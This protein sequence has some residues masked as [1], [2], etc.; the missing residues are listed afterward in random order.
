MFLDM[1]AYSAHMSKNQ[2]HAMKRVN[3]LEEILHREV[4]RYGGRLVK[5]MGDGAMAEFPTAIAA[6]TCAEVILQVIRERNK[7]IEPAD[8]FEVRIG[9]HLGDVI[10]KDADLFG[11]TVNI[12]ARIQPFADKGGIAMSHHVLMSVRNQIK[13]KGAY[14]GFTKLKNIP[15]KVR[16]YLVP[17]LDTPYY[18]WI[19]MR[20]NPVNTRFRAVM[21]AL[22]TGIAIWAGHH[23][24]AGPLLAPQIALLYVT[25]VVQAEPDRT[26]AQVM[27]DQV[28]EEMDSRGSRIK[29]FRWKDHG[30]VANLISRE[31][32]TDRHNTEKVDVAIGSV[33]RKGRLA[34]YIIGRIEAVGFWSWMLKIRV[35]SGETQSVVATFKAKGDNPSDVANTIMNE[36]SAWARKQEKPGAKKTKHK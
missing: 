28:A 30:W 13:L 6:V 23:F 33:A 21:L 5:F 2:E 20:R 27:A 12:A 26:K 9:L 11:D 16:I 32:I 1:V 35:V 7:G 17:P 4:P 24:M 8:W 29:G 18:R 34:Y 25:P 3:D 31:G 36:L 10:E 15:G 22:A 14:L 19:I